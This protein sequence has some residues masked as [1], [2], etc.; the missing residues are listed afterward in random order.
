MQ[1]KP[2]AK[3]C[4]LV[5]DGIRKKCMAQMAL[6]AL[7]RIRKVRKAKKIQESAKVPKV[8]VQIFWNIFDNFRQIK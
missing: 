7:R 3:T 1:G 2:V 8:P 6:L 5:Y 4:S